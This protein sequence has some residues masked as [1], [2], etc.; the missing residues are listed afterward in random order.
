MGNSFADK[1]DQITVDKMVKTS[2]LFIL[3]RMSQANLEVFK[4]IWPTI[5]TSRRQDVMRELVEISEANFEVDFEPVFLLGLADPDPDVRA[6]AINGLWEHEQPDLINPLLHLLQTDEAP[7]VRATAASSLGR[8]LYLSELEELDPRYVEPV[9]KALF[10]TIHL[11]GEDV[12]V[13]RRAIES[14]AFLSEEGVAD[15][16]ENAYYDD[17][18]KMQVSAI[19]AMGRS[20]DPVWGS[21]V[22]TELDNENLEIRFEAARACGELELAEAVS[23][24]IELIDQDPDIQIQEMSIWALG[25]IGGQT[26]REAL[27]ICAG[28]EN[29]AIASA[30]EEALDEINLFADSLNMFNFE[31]DLEFDWDDFDKLETDDHNNPYRLN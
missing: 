27:E 26:A 9:K 1:L 15:I 4:T 7:L 18:E 29:E 17:N 6:L 31:E 16:I 28:S 22:I 24:L 19:F 11:P 21:R 30:A 13:R 23:R 8:F 10:D 25:R 20:A 5:E 12:E 3:S 14:I 2:S